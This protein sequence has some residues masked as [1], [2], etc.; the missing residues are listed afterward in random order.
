LF[1]GSSPRGEVALS[2]RE[3]FDELARELDYDRFDLHPRWDQPAARL[4]DLLDRYQPHV[5][6]FSGHGDESGGLL[7]EDE[8]GQAYVPN[9][10]A[11]AKVFEQHRGRVCCV[12]LNACYSVEQA[13]LIAKHVDVVIGM[14]DQIADTAA[15]KF[16]Q[17]F[18]KALGSGDS[19]GQAFD[20]AK[21]KLALGNQASPHILKIHSG[22]KVDPHR[23]V[24]GVDKPST[25]TTDEIANAVKIIVD[26]LYARRKLR[27]GT[28]E[29]R[30]ETTAVDEAIKFV[31]RRFTPD[32]GS[33]VAGARLEKVIGYGN[34]GTVWEAYDQE[35]QKKV[36]V[37]VFKLEA[38]GEGQMLYRFGRS[39]RAM[40]LLSESNRR[41]RHG[42]AGRVIEFHKP[43]PTGLAFSM[44]L[45]GGGD[46]REIE[47]LGWDREKKIKVMI[48]LCAALE[49]SHANGVIHRDIKPANIVLDARGLP[50]LTDFDIAD[51][52]FA[53]SLSTSVEGGLGTPIFAAPEQLAEAEQRPDERA[54]IYSLGRLLHFLL[55]EHSPGLALE[56]DPT[57]ENLGGEPSALVEVVRR[58]TQFEPKRRFATVA[59]M[60]HALET[61]M[62]GAAAWKASVSRTGRALRR[63]WQIATISGF[64]V[65]GLVVAL[66]YQADKAERAEQQRATAERE[67]ALRLAAEDAKAETEKAYAK[68]E[69]LSQKLTELATEERD[70]VLEKNRR[71]MRLNGMREELARLKVGSAEYEELS[72]KIVAEEAALAR[73][74]ADLQRLEEGR[75][76]LEKELEEA[77]RKNPVV[78][79]RPVDSDLDC[80]ERCKTEG[81]CTL[82][83]GECKAT[84]EADCKASERC[85]TI[86][87]CT[88]KDGECKATAD[89]DC[90]ASERCKTAGR[91][92]A[93]DGEC[94]ATAD[95]D[96][97]A[98]EWCR[99]SGWCTV[100][101]DNCTITSDADCRAS[102]RCETA[103]E[104]T[105]Q[106][107]EC[108]ATSDADC[109]ASQS[110]KKD[111]Y[112]VAKQGQ[113]RATSNADCKASQFCKIAGRCTA[114]E[115][116]C[117]ATWDL[118]CE[119]SE[120]CKSG[121]KCTASGGYCI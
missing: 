93:K 47:R 31:R 103:G 7:L 34:F 54:D 27:Q 19:V 95:A 30:A 50:V 85:K 110:C 71:E 58:A 107:G 52:R 16:S 97:K 18:Y 48:D 73:T 101:A 111:G 51:I 102:T 43:D 121:E 25:A 84:T 119:A 22:P 8:E 32:V 83:H 117:Q 15:R 57:L 82:Q 94:K 20:D 37:K 89:A 78:V 3:E 65:A 91:C 44:E 79:R 29:S 114:K 5:L 28:P 35:L 61:C 21:L 120:F 46:L 75:A 53:T 118:D 55:L 17:A 98:S 42:E 4:P 26:K 33:V 56:K 67:L 87:R 92:T 49:Y 76:A 24:L 9:P 6:H 39:I 40:R 1:L 13:V 109:K 23:L 86:G 88:A 96:C 68:Y 12:V 80:E 70:L 2:L 41:K 63:H 112:C 74:E 113:C 11:V 59:Q 99:T 72:K 66:V 104:C 10:A 100:K 108:K 45:H 115:G 81:K 116:M 64:L 69:E 36:A 62:S 60:R 106:G 77:K 90:K 105:E 38:L 14:S